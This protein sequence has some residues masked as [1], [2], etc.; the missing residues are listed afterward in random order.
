MIPSLAQRFWCD[1]S[2]QGRLGC[3]TRGVVPGTQGH[4]RTPCI[5][6]GSLSAPSKGSPARC[7]EAQ[8][9]NPAAAN[10]L[11]ACVT[12]PR[13]GAA[14]WR[15]TERQGRGISVPPS[16][17]YRPPGGLVQ[18]WTLRQGSGGR[19]E[20]LHFLPSPGGVWAADLHVATL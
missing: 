17:A 1:F 9:E 2:S 11:L 4:W 7:W 6:Q 18:T 10:V 15:V 20:S 16:G 14:T 19:S 3:H 13:S 5:T 12:L 8:V